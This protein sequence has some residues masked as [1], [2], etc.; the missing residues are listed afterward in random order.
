[1]KSVGSGDIEK[2]A[3]PIMERIHGRA[4]RRFNQTMIPNPIGSPKSL[5]GRCVKPENR[6]RTEELWIWHGTYW[7]NFLKRSAR[8]VKM[9]SAM[10]MALSTSAYLI[11]PAAEPEYSA[12]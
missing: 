4:E 6:F 3:V 9:R 5:Q 1:M 12:L 11:P 7:A 8:S 10:R 2:I